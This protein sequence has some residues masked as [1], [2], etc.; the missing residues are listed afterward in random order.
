MNSAEVGA[1]QDPAYYDA[2]IKALRMLKRV[3]GLEGTFFLHEGVL[4]KADTLLSEQQNAAFVVEVNA[5]ISQ[6]RNAKR[7]I[8]RALF[9]FDGGNVFIFHAAPF[10]IGLIF[11]DFGKAEIIE[12]ATEEYFQKWAA[13]FRIPPE[14]VAGLATLEFDGSDRIVLQ[15]VA[16]SNDDSEAAKTETTIV[17]NA[18]EDGVPVPEDQIPPIAPLSGDTTS[19]ELE[20]SEEMKSDLEP[21]AVEESTVS[22]NAE[23]NWKSFREKIENLFSKVVG[24]A[25]AKRLIERELTSM[26]VTGNGRLSPNQ[27][28]PF[29]TKVIQR[30][31]DRSLRKQLEIEM[32]SLVEAHIP[33]FE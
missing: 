2:P 21:A 32:I 31:K 33:N 15:N 9:G 29:G 7:P 25:Q 14:S 24:R 3:R 22:L 23:T 8:S 11:S 5:L 17:A 30:V 26:G 1:M 16:D 19:G 28:R 13:S 10:T 20:S 4:L 6:F 18:P 27:F 12:K